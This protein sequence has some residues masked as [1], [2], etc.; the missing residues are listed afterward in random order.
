MVK[1]F[2]TVYWLC[3]TS[4]GWA[5]MVARRRVVVVVAAIVVQ[6]C[7]DNTGM[8]AALTGYSSETRQQ[9]PTSKPCRFKEKSTWAWACFRM[10]LQ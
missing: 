1:L 10:K 3:C 8:W 9:A 4:M 2:V 5:P 6:I 7:C